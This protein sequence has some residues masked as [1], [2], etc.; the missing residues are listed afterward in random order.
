[1]SDE[2]RISISADD[3]QL[4][5]QDQVERILRERASKIAQHYTQASETTGEQIQVITFRRCGHKYGIELRHLTEIRPLVRWTRVPG[6][7]GYYSGVIH[8]R[9]EIMSLID[10]ATLFKSRTAD[11][12][13]ETFAI[14]VSDGVSST[15]FLADAVDDV[16]DIPPDRIHPPL[17]TFREMK[18]RYIRGLGMENLALLDVEKMLSD[19][20]LNVNH[21][22]KED[23][24]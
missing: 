16:H 17:A 20:W 15:A 18:R 5:T 8:L 9:G 24:L 3:D 12:G 23:L 21:E 2:P 19:E 1:M 10:L 4:L 11:A 14:V 6:I 7:P 22:S 13:E